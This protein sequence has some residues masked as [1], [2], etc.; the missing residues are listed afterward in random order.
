M[1]F[2]PNDQLP[3][4]LRDY[5]DIHTPTTR[6]SRKFL[7]TA[8]LPH[9]GALMGPG[10]KIGAFDVRPCLWALLIGPSTKSGKSTALSRAAKATR[11]IQR[12]K[13]DLYDEALTRWKQACAATPKGE[14]K[15]EPPEEPPRIDFDNDFTPE[16]LVDD[17]ARNEQLAAGTV[18]THGEFG[19]FLKTAQKKYMT[20]LVQRLTDIKGGER[21]SLARKTGGHDGGGTRTA[22]NEP[23]LAMAVATN[24]DWLRE[25]MSASD[26]TGG[27]LARFLIVEQADSCGLREA[28][29]P[30]PVPT[31]V[32]AWQAFCWKMLT[33]QPGQGPWTLSRDARRRYVA[34]FD[35]WEP[36]V[37]DSDP[38][39]TG[40]IARKQTEDCLS[41]A[42]ICAKAAM[43]REEE[44]RSNI[45]SDM[46]MAHAIAL[47]DFYIREVMEL[48]E[49]TL[50][51]SH[52]VI[53]EDRV[54]AAIAR[55]VAQN[56]GRKYI[57]KKEYTLATRGIFNR[58]ESAKRLRDE[59]LESLSES[60]KIVLGEHKNK[61]TGREETRIAVVE[62]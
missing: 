11:A 31:L 13:D 37:Q 1:T 28:F 23:F 24:A 18:M 2:P 21:I 15:P 30:K 46:A 48:T 52:A 19:G 42:M 33:E 7:A 32:E 43:V 20:G 29:P 56:N 12:H 26:V 35:Q 50:C 38:R 39:V 27:F 22:V 49:T 58:V 61:K 17:L 57:T 34:W 16:R 62:M 14:V 53:M 59:I 5:L 54:L 6:T 41:I 10:H 51:T 60:G 9:L 4:F 44:T 3:P 8:I 25:A 36:L 40:S 47:A 45:V 55:R